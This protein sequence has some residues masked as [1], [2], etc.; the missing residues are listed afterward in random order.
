MVYVAVQV[1]SVS[2]DAVA[3]TEVPAMVTAGL[4]TYGSAVFAN[5]SSPLIVT[6]ITSPTF[7]R[8]GSLSLL[9]VTVNKDNS[10]SSPS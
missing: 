2:S 5:L 4:S 3:S 9:E 1:E 7:A 6:V 8:L 10:G